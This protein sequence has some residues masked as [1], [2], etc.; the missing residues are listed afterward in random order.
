MNILKIPIN[1]GKTGKIGTK[2]VAIFNNNGNFVVFENVC[3]HRGCQIE[4]N[5]SQKTWDC[6]CHGSSFTSDGAVIRGPARQPLRRLNFH[7]EGDL[8]QLEEGES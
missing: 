6:P 4:W 5:S 8:I 7:I 1:E 2:Q 3:T